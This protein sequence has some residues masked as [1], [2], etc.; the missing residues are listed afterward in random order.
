[1][2]IMPGADWVGPHHDNGTMSRYDVVCVHTIVGNPPA[3]AAHFSTRADGY[4]YQSRDTAYRS[5]TNYEGNHRVIAIENDDFG[6]EYGAWDVD[7]GHTVP[8][9]T[10]AQIET[11]A[12]VC[13]WAHTTHGVPLVPCPDSRPS[14]RGIAYHRQGIDGNFAAEGYAYGG[15]VTDGERWSIHEGK[16]CPGDRRIAQLPQ[17]VDRARA[18]VGLDPLEGDVPLSNDDINRIWMFP[19]TGTAPDGSKQ[20]WPAV[21]WLTVM[22][23]RIAGIEPNVAELV[24]RDPV[25]VDEASVAAQLAPALAPVLVD[26]VTSTIQELSEED[27][28]RIA[29]AVADENARR[30][31]A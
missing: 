13:A 28:R 11:I 3:H 20:T 6:P 21:V 23:F 26:A 12:K 8:A 30:Q 29:T 10:A 18:L 14:S 1:M 25:D 5:A 27:L 19:C 17:I 22:A 16:V 7:D 31:V 2:A 9:F 15:R 4:L 24:G